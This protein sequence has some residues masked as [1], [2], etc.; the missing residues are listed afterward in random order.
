[1]EIFGDDKSESSSPSERI[2][3]TEDESPEEFVG[4]IRGMSEE[5]LSEATKEL[6]D[7][8]E[9]IENLS[10]ER[11]LMLPEAIVNAVLKSAGLYLGCPCNRDDCA[12]IPPLPI[13]R[14][15]VAGEMIHSLRE[16]GDGFAAQ[17][18]DKLINNAV[19]M[20]Q[21]DP[22]MAHNFMAAMLS[23]IMR[24]SQYERT[25]HATLEVLKRFGIDINDLPN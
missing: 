17:A 20:I 15:R 8:G 2:G 14:L 16:E 18:L 4:R 1:M 5:E 10:L 19:E 24:G 12:S 23:L 22:E 6:I 13:Q 25:A 9:A 11:I 21:D 3:P 7:S